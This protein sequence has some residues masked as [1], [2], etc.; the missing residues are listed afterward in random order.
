MAN[1]SSRKRSPTVQFKLDKTTR[2]SLRRLASHRKDGPKAVLT[3]HCR[4]ALI[5]QPALNEHWLSYCDRILSANC[6]GKSRAVAAL[7]KQFEVRRSQ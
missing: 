2:T 7:L 5:P 6:M 3:L 1:K 4:F